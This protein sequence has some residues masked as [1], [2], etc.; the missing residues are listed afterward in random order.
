MRARTVVAIVA[1]LLAV[2]A[3]APAVWAQ[4]SLVVS[5]WGGKWKDTVEKVI[6]KAFTAK[7]GMPV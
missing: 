3:P 2:V 1:S 4:K 7:T 5:V 6:G